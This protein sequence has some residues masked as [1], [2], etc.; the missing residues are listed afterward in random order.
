[1]TEHDITQFKIYRAEAERSGSSLTVKLYYPRNPEPI[2]GRIPENLPWGVKVFEGLIKNNYA[3]IAD[4]ENPIKPAA[5]GSLYV[6]ND[7][8]ILV[9]RR[10]IKAPTHPMYHSACGGYPTEEEYKGKEQGLMR[11]AL[12]ETAEE[13]LLIT[14]EKTPKLIVPKDSKEYT[15]ESARRLGLDLKTVEVNVETLDPSDTLKVYSGEGSS[16]YTARAFLDLLWESSTSLTALQIRKLPL[17]VEDVIPI[18]AE[19]MISNE[20]NF[21]H[22]NRES[23]FLRQDELERKDFGEILKN[24]RVYQTKIENGVP[25]VFTPEYREPLYGPEKILVRH[26]HVW[27]PEDMLVTCL[28]GLGVDGYKG[29]KYEIELWKT[30]TKLEGKSLLPSD[31]LAQ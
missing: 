27:A 10:D 6:F 19:G 16:I 5:A 18:D 12:R 20:G 24:P 13:C 2:K 14:R 22:F 17:S 30:K 7:G 8:N 4:A 25:R 3:V 23:Y 1:M 28:D 31:V 29:R 15:V 11:T 26:P 21:I 9:H